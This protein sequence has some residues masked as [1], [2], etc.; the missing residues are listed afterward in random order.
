M[1]ASAGWDSSITMRTGADSP[2]S[3]SHV[4]SM[5]LSANVGPPYGTLLEQDQPSDVPL[6]AFGMLLLLRYSS[7]N[8][9]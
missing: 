2:L 6:D 4:K 5:D 3:R 7:A 9:L 8:G 1:P